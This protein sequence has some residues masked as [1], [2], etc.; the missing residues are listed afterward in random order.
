[1]AN[2]HC[3]RRIYVNQ[4]CCG[5]H[6]SILGWRL[7][8]EITT[9]WRERHMA[10]GYWERYVE[11]RGRVAAEFERLKTGGCDANSHAQNG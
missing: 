10:P 11:V 1:M 3:G 4:W 8:A 7:A 9:A 6:K 2:I 5:A